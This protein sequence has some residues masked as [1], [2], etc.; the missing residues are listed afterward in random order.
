[1]TG[2]RY[3][4]LAGVLRQCI[5]LG[6]VAADRALP[7]EAAL[8]AQHGVSRITVRRALE[9]LR[10]EGLVEPRKG[11]GWFVAEPPVRSP[12]GT[13]AHVSDALAAD[14]RQTSR[15]L[16]DYAFTDVG[17]PVADALGPAVLRIRRLYEVDGRPYDLVTS[18]LPEAIGSEITRKELELHG[19]WAS[20]KRHGMEITHARQTLTA[21][22]A[23]AGDARRLQVER[24]HPLLVVLRTSSTANGPVL[25][26]EHRHPSGRLVLDIEFFGESA[27]TSEGAGLRLI[28]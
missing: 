8:A 17:P 4:D 24:G 21:A 18:Y 26:S 11:S 9:E 25:V 27:A 20:L 14:G 16:L 6:E 7:S 19:T 23:T 28:S 3:A 10:K 1:M 5:A 12:L 15:K 13:F 2:P 22:A